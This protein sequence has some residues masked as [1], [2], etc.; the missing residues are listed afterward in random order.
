MPLFERVATLVRANLNDLLDQ[1]ED[2]EKLIKQVILDMENQLLQVKTQVAVAIADHHV[3]DKKRLEHEERATDWMRR[4]ELA[5]DKDQ[6]DLARAA[7]ARAMT[8]RRLAANYERQIADQQAEVEHLKNALRQLDQ[9]LAESRAQSE[10]L[11]A[12]HRRARALRNTTTSR[13]GARHRDHGATF[14]R[15]REK[16]LHAEATGRAVSE[17]A[18]D[19]VEQRLGA[20]ADEA[21]IE[22]MLAE[23]KARRGTG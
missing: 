8:C 13:S 15:M 9:K 7:L 1:A 12:Q 16:V 14:R 18:E 10:T 17:L 6:E 4:A 23:L 11:I 22:R 3:L 21:E 2:P 20:L 19:D 5:L